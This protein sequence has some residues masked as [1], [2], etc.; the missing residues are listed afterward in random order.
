ML[1]KNLRLTNFR[2]FKGEQLISF[3]TYP[4]RNV[5]IIMGENGSG[6]TTLAQAFTW[7]L[8]GDTDF[9]D[10]SMLSKAVALNMLPDEE[11][12]VRVEL[13]L[14]HNGIEYTIIREQ[15][16]SKDS[17]GNLRRPSQTTFKI[18]FKGADG[19]R[20]FVPDLETEIRMKEILPKELSKYFFFDGERIEKMSKEIRRGKSKEFAEAVKSLLGLSA[21]TAAL[22][23]LKSRSPSSVI[24][25]YDNS[26]DAGSDVR[27]AQYTKEIDELDDKIDAITRRLAEIDKEEAI[28]QDKCDELK[29]KI[30]KFKDSE[31]LAKEREALRK[32]L[33]GLISSKASST[34]VLLRTFNNNAQQYFAKKMMKDALQLLSEADKLDKGIPDI[35]ERTIKFL[36]D[37]GSC[38][39]NNKIEFNN[40]AYKALMK[41]LEYIPPQSLGSLIGQF[42]RDC[43]SKSK[44]GS[45][46]FEDISE[47]YRIIRNFE[48]DYADVENKIKLI[49]ERLVNMENV[50][51]LQKELINYERRL[52]YLKKERDELNIEQ[53][54]YETQKKL[55]IAE[56]KELTLK[57]EAN[58]KIEVYK[59]YAQYMYDVL[60]D[61][62]TQKET[63]TR[64]QLQKTVNG[65][66]KHIYNGGLA[67][68]L[69][70]NYNVNIIVN[71][72]RGYNSDVETSTAQ[73]I[74]VIFAFI[75]G[76]IK[77]ARDSQNDE[78]EM[79][80]SE[81][82][83]LVMDAPLSAF[84]KTRIQTVCDILP[85]VAEQV[86][87][88][89][90]DTDGE[91]AETHMGQQ[92]GAR[93]LFDKKN[94]FETYLVTR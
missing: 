4:D 23:H 11:A 58:R 1:L 73:S 24:R 57:D 20:E 49:E 62:Y 28:A 32:K 72:F 39:C 17:S 59:A 61:E 41:V 69:D 5:T 74:S 19:Q 65:I 56:R 29:E 87:I 51:L 44:G 26:Y 35:H 37:R 33:N 71:D 77:M 63:E 43:E 82:Y 31:D 12:S 36:I 78:N 94:E 25:S 38:I 16:Y 55:K 47:Q 30:V 88:F 84:D 68:S 45:S 70:E 86:I 9:E 85:K 92:V 2:Q 93:Y 21:F 22:N 90:K 79:L 3:S 18:A 80:V 75:A 48:T 10:K 14:V 27:I 83:P 60:L 42:V 6:K 53:G 15:K 54:S 52:N 8:Y 76:V 81:P 89:I 40:D 46:L 50:G 67:L 91:L 13:D 66:F 7:C 64:N 34:A